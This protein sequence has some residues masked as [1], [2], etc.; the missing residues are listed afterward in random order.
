MYVQEL[1]MIEVWLVNGDKD[2][3]YPKNNKQAIDLINGINNNGVVSINIDR[4]CTR[5]YYSSKVVKVELHLDS[6]EGE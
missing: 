3:I 2:E 1:P 5:Y 6:Q 4:W